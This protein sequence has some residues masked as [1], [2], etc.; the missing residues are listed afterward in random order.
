MSMEREL[1]LLVRGWR[2]CET[3]SCLALSGAFGAWGEAPHADLNTLNMPNVNVINLF[4]LQPPPGRV[5]P[6]AGIDNIIDSV[7]TVD[8]NMLI[9][10]MLNV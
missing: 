10:S 8:I 2:E 9:S 5:R 7:Y 4:T 6:A 3:A 1:L